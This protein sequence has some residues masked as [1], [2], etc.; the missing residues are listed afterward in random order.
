MLPFDLSFFFSVAGE[1]CLTDFFSDV[2]RS[3]GFDL[4]IWSCRGHN[5]EFP[6]SVVRYSESSKCSLEC[7]LEWLNSLIC[8]EWV[9]KHLPRFISLF[10]FVVFG[11]K[12]GGICITLDCIIIGSSL[13]NL[14]LSKLYAK[15][16]AVESFS[17]DILFYA[18]RVAM[19]AMLATS[20]WYFDLAFLAWVRLNLLL[21]YPCWTVTFIFEN[22]LRLPFD[23][24]IT[25]LRLETPGDGVVILPCFLSDFKSGIVSSCPLIEP[26][27]VDSSL[28]VPSDSNCS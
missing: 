16:S 10:M 27:T 13:C 23:V 6:P 28:L 22:I 9:E 19:L 14:M 12:A 2:F 18:L 25:C 5:S 24:G 7:L 21:V 15:R 4:C 11:L 8:E 3:L 26:S 20:L 1:R 17:C